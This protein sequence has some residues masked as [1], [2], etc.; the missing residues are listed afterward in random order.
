MVHT[1]FFSQAKTFLCGLKVMAQVN[2]LNL[3]PELRLMIYKYF[4]GSFMSTD[5][6]EYFGGNSA[7]YHLIRNGTSGF[8]GY[9]PIHRNVHNPW[10]LL[11]VCKLIRDE[12]QP[13][14]AALDLQIVYDFRYFTTEDMEAWGVAAGPER[15]SRMRRWVV[16]AVR[17][18]DAQNIT[19]ELEGDEVANTNEGA[20]EPEPASKLELE[21]DD[22]FGE[23]EKFHGY[24]LSANLDLWPCLGENE[25][26]DV[27]NNGFVWH[28]WDEWGECIGCS[29]CEL[30][31][32][33]K[34]EE[35]YAE[36]WKRA[37]RAETTID[38]LCAPLSIISDDVWGRGRR[39]RDD[40]K[41]FMR[42][43][44]AVGYD[45]QWRR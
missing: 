45:V 15:V 4:L 44:E 12:F 5:S 8:Q 11:R 28:D 20:G 30:F 36:D 25:N 41:M 7:Y 18:C 13:L 3:A 27:D 39:A 9:E 32:E 22:I 24:T 17:H 37:G 6:C 33:E 29:D 10:G 40:W 26:C 21:D 35:E 23:D 38:L 1:I 43:L 19:D 34:L 14:L 16:S 42:R 31:L 2:F